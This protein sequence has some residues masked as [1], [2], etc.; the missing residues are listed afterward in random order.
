Q[1]AIEKN[2]TIAQAQAR[3][4]AARGRARQAGLYPNPSVG[5]TG[6][7]ISPGPIIRGGEYGFFVQQD[8]VLAGKLQKNR[9]IL[10][11]E[12]NRTQIEAEAQKARVLNTVRILFYRALAAQWKVEVRTNLRKLVDEAVTVTKQLQNVGQADQPDL[13]QIEVE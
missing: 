5:A 3:I 1:V 7:E 11:Q 2:P 13:L 10:E 12:V 4:E 6:D 9:N 8:I